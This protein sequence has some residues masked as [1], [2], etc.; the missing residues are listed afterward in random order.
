MPEEEG[1]SAAGTVAAAVVVRRDRSPGASILLVRRGLHALD[2]REM[3]FAGAWVVP[4]GGV[5]PQD[6]ARGHERVDLDTAIRRAAVRELREEVRVELRE[7]ALSD[8][9]EIETATPTGRRYRVHYF[10]AVLPTGQ[11]PTVDGVELTGLRWCRPSEATAAAEQG[12]LLIPP[13]TLETLE[14]L[15]VRDQES[16]RAPERP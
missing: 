16:R 3:P 11:L 8:L 9:W 2:G 12:Q 15:A 5:D 1:G 10:D 4:G 14:R 13:A 6:R 7:D